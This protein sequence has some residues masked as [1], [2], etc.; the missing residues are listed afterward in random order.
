MTKYKSSAQKPSKSSQF[1]LD[2]HETFRREAVNLKK[3]EV[4]G[5]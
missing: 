4:E 5:S 2:L 1:D 3:D